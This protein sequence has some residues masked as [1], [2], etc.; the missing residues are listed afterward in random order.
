L[1]SAGFGIKLTR[2][3]V[4]SLIFAFLLGGIVISFFTGSPA[5]TRILAL[6][7]AFLVAVHILASLV[8][9]TYLDQTH[10]GEAKSRRS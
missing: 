3:K 9:P 6:F 4:S 10:R 5:L 1:R 8:R 2:V 7:L